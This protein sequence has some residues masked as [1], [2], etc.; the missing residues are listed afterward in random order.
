MTLLEILNDDKNLGSGFTNDFNTDF[1]IITY[2][3]FN[4]DFNED[5]SSNQEKSDSLD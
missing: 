3:S 4:K 5:F 1:N 2:E